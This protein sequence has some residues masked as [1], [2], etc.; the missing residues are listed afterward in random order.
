MQIPKFRLY[1]HAP[2]T[3]IAVHGGPGGVGQ[4]QPF[5]Q[6]LGKEY[7]VVEPLLVSETLDGQLQELH[8]A[9]T[10]N[11][12]EPVVLVGHSYGAMLCYIFAAKF[13][14][15]VKK[16]VMVSSGMLTA[17]TAHGI[18]ATRLSR[19]SPNRQNELLQARDD[20]KT[21][22]GDAKQ[23]AFVQLFSLVQQADAYELLPH[24]NDLV[25]VRPHLYDSVWH[26]I[27]TLRNSGELA[28][29]GAQI[30]CP[31]V[32][33]HGDYDPRPANGIKNVL[34]K[35]VPAAQFILLNK[36]GHYPWYEKQAS[37]EFF[38][39]LFECIG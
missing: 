15:L 18:T 7:S 25:V 33:I 14:Q 2:Y 8:D 35:Y 24:S 39:R 21:S 13:P 32:A 9:I 28:A 11:T 34:S 23:K 31:V 3:I 6:E 22:T 19:L 38:A 37:E 29:F 26:G 36:C 30:R 20:Y 16:L 10:A 27:E 5:A 12:R 4:A 1:G 17:E